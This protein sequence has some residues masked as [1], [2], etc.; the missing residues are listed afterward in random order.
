M[1][2]ILIIIVLILLASG[3]FYFINSSNKSEIK[4]DKDEEL[5]KKGLERLEKTT[6]WLITEA[7]GSLHKD[8]N[9]IDNI[10][11]TL[12][13]KFKLRLYNTPKINPV[14]PIKLRYIISSRGIYY[15]INLIEKSYHKDK[16][17][18]Y[19]VITIT[20]LDWA[21]TQL[22]DT[23]FLVSETSS[24]KSDR[25]IIARDSQFFSTFEIDQTKILEIDFQNNI[26]L[27]YS[28]KPWY[29]NTNYS[30][31][32]DLTSKEVIILEN[33]EYKL[34]PYKDLR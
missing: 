24:E 3:Y 8:P 33:G 30:K 28:L 14:A 32:P 11:S 9:Q 31:Y 2:T 20:S 13:N 23:V 5:D 16:L 17:Y 1:K 7:T 18:E 6:E 15:D 34:I 21:T 29:F 10:E 27:R 4:K 25:T 12:I 26:K 22:K 19:W